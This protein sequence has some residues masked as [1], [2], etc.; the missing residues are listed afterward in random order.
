VCA[1]RRRHPPAG[2]LDPWRDSALPGVWRR[3]RGHLVNAGIEP[4][5]LS[6]NKIVLV[7][8]SLDPVWL[9]YDTDLAHSLSASRGL[10]ATRGLNAFGVRT[11]NNYETS[12]TCADK[13]STTIALARAGIT[14][15][16]ALLAFTPR[17]TLRAIESLGYPAVLKP[18]F[19]SPGRLLAR[20]EER[21]R[22]KHTLPEPLR[23]RELILL[24]RKPPPQWACGGLCTRHSG[25]RPVATRGPFARHPT[26]E[27][28]CYLPTQPL[29]AA[30]TLNLTRQAA[31]W[32][33]ES[34][35]SERYG[36]HHGAQL[37]PARRL[38][39][40]GSSCIAGRARPDQ[41]FAVLYLPG[42][43]LG[44]AGAPTC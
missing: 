23:L 9:E 11:I 15:P 19:G 30:C 41:A 34:S 3:A 31:S 18:V 24:E 14:Q 16:R 33:C 40:I 1:V 25:R 29:V 28:Y 44:Q 37:E 38:R 8:L 7:P 12:A 39:Q 20:V 27:R 32:K 26:T 43:W 36:R 10:Y 35:Y 13:V 17:S 22:G 21:S 42:S 5:L 4:E 6:D 2:R